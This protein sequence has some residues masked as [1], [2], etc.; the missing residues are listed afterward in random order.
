M[1]SDYFEYEVVLEEDDDTEFTYSGVTHGNNYY[2]ALDNVLEYYSSSKITSVKLE[3][4]EAPGSCLIVTKELLRELR[5]G[6]L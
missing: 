2:E 6:A 3:N 5:E 1:T 4:F